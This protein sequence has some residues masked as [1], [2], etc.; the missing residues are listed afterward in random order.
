[1]T[2][3]V[4]VLNATTSNPQYASLS[5]WNCVILGF[6]I[7]VKSYMCQNGLIKDHTKYFDFPVVCLSDYY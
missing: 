5:Q 7:L 3:L 4:Q 1:M 6:K 2:S